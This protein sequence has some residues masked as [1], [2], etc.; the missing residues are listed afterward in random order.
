MS[1][2]FAAPVEQFPNIERI[3]TV[4][5]SNA[6]D[7]SYPASN[8]LTYDPTKPWIAT[9]TNPIITWDLGVTRTFDVVSLVWT[10][11]VEGSTWGLEGSLNGS[12]WTTL[13]TSLTAPAWSH[14]VVGQSAQNRKNAL[15]KNHTLW[16]NATTVSYRYLR[17]T[18]NSQVPGVFPSVGRL[19][20]GLKFKPATGWQYGSSIEFLDTSKKDRTDQGALILAPQRPIPI[21]NVKMDFLTKTEMMDTVWEFNYWRGMA[22][23]ILTCVDAEDT[24]YLQKNLIYGTISE[25]RRISFDSYNTHSATWVIESIA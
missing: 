11:F 7:P 24:K 21:V 15:L 20:V 4:P 9:A 6:D 3:L 13:T 5:V 18:P 12:T 23:E 17:I 19:F 1:I 2:F 8:L 16:S 22:R 10:N 14:Y 25:G